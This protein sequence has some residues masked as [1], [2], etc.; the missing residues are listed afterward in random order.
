MQYI[1][2]AHYVCVSW[3][4]VRARVH[5]REHTH[6]ERVSEGRVCV[7]VVHGSLSL[8]L[9]RPPPQQQPHTQQQQREAKEGRWCGRPRCCRHCRQ[10]SLLYFSWLWLRLVFLSDWLL[11]FHPVFPLLPL[12][13]QL[14]DHRLQL[15][16]CCWDLFY[17]M[18]P[19]HQK[20]NLAALDLLLTSPLWCRYNLPPSLYLSHLCDLHPHL[21]SLHL[22]HF[23]LHFHLH[24]PP[25]PTSFLLLL[26][27]HCCFPSLVLKLLMLVVFPVLVPVRSSLPL[28]LPFPSRFAPVMM[29]LVT[30]P[31]YR[32][33]HLLQRHQWSL[34]HF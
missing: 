29:F 8:T 32:F 28:P 2:W 17:S 22:L 21:L 9:T 27:S 26:F 19:P 30:L 10:Y 15:L 24:F 4:E 5:A 20:I 1:Q 31:V 23:H 6:S 33:G 7:W 34:F 14:L 16:V 13:H 25:L 18:L 12:K 11:Y 3:G